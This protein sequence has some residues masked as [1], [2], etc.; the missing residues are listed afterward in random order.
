MLSLALCSAFFISG[1]RFAAY[2][3]TLGKGLGLGVLMENPYLQIVGLALPHIK[4][5]L[6]EMCEDAKEQIRS[7]SNEELGC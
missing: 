5:I 3:K 6:D 4:E 1:H 7:I 2:C